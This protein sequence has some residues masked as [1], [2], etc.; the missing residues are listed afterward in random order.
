MATTTIPRGRAAGRG[1]WIAGGVAVI[2]LALIA[3]LL[4]TRQAPAPAAGGG[5]TTTVSLGTLT[6]SV[7][8]SGTI[9]AEQ[10]ID[11]PFRASGSV[12][13]VLVS[14]GDLVASGQPLAR[15]DS[16]DLASQVAS[17]E[18][19]LASARARLEQ[20]QAGN[21]T[22]EQVAASQASLDSAQASLQRARTNNTTAADIADAEAQLRSAQAKLDDLRAQPKADALASA[23]ASYDQAVANMQSQRTGLAVAKQKADSAAQQ[24]A[25]TLR[26]RQDEYSRIYWDNREK[27]RRPGDLPQA[28]K[29]SEASA[30]RAVGSA[31]ESLSQAQLAYEQARQDEV[32]GVA[33]AESQL[34]EAET[35]LRVTREGATEA[36]LIQAQASVDQAKASLQKLRQGGTAA[37]VAVAQASVAQ[38]QANLDQLTAPATASDL[39]IERASVAQAEQSLAQARLQLENAT[40]TA[41]FAG[42][43]TQ[44]DIVPGSAVGSGTPALT[45]VNRDPLHVDLKLNENDIAMV[46]LGQ[47]VALTIDAIS[48]WSA[49]GTVSYI[50]PAAETTNDVVTYRVRVSF[51]DADA[52]VKVGMTANLEIVTAT[53]EGALLVPNTALQ[54]KGAGRVVL[55]PNPDGTT[56]EVDVTIGLSDG[57][58]TEILSGLSAGETVV[59]N[60]GAQATK[61]SGGGMFGR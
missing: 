43:V 45:L 17:A 54:P 7:A 23:Q 18:A 51:P 58:S 22:P 31:E 32:S 37:D 25:D 46:Q 24:A 16:R 10:T 36:E 5:T 2:V 30:L 60:P 3:A 20:Q 48:G 33:K 9:A 14:E 6:A 27:E 53:R 1:R 4:V 19:S 52:Q 34:R 8:G 28:D 50:A 29:D 38:A 40:L 55:V 56:R 35:K 57:V 41:P 13:E 49:Q 39:T 42:V 12:T 44:V 21:A 11:L 15:I 47:P 59:A 61:P 26:D